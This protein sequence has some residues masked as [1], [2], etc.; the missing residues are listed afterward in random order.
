MASGELPQEAQA[1]S[2]FFTMTY[3]LAETKQKSLEGQQNTDKL[4]KNVLDSSWMAEKTRKKRILFFK[5]EA[6]KLLKTKWGRGK[7]SQNDP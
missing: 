1:A 6:R 4:L 2:G 5:N 7:N 3:E